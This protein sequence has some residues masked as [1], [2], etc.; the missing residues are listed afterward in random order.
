ML[1]NL[2]VKLKLTFLPCQENNFRP[3]FLE[4]R[5]LIWCLLALFILKLIT[6]PFLIYFPKSVF[7]SA[8]V[9]T[10]LIELL[11]QERKSLGLQS[12][13]E[14]MA[15]DNAAVLKAQDILEKD[16]FSHQSPEGIGPWYWFKVAGYNYEVAGENLA[17]GFLDSEEVHKAWLVSPSHRVNL[18][19]PK[20]KEVGIA[21]T[22]GDF[23]GNETTVVVQLFGVPKQT[24][25]EPKVQTKEKAKK[26]EISSQPEIKKEEVPSQKTEK[27][28]I[29]QETVSGEFATI[30]KEVAP[31]LKETKEKVAF[32]LLSFL[33]SD[34]HKIL[35][36]I[37]YG[38][39]GLIILALIINIFIRFD[40]QHT[41][42]I[43]KAL[44]F[45][46][47]LVLF[48]LVDKA[49]IT[50]LIPHNFNIY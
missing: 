44:G 39:F 47:V 28:E 26:E 6:V 24:V 2:S 8:I 3:K 49:V 1:K 40:I 32:S 33:T 4:S 36:V 22:K 41:D 16:Y 35:Q 5:I 45:I 7:F 18:L 31:A 27:E 21:I 29:T 20:Y 23:Q 19:N 42:L 11:N 14:N 9:K 50:K 38:F 30:M 46:A 15:L 13:K 34:Y 25:S 17:I 43:L 12:L 10:T 48:I 37:I